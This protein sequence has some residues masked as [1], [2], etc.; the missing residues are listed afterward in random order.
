MNEFFRNKRVLVAGARGFVGTNL[1]DQLVQLGASVRGSVTRR[2]PPSKCGSVE[3]I[4]SDL[5][6]RDDCKRLVDEIDYVFMAAAC[7]SGAAVI[8]TNP[9]AHLTPNVVMNSYMLE[10]ARAAGVKKFCFVSSNV[11]YPVTDFP[12]AEDHTNFEFFEK[13]FIVGWMKQ[14]SELMCEMYSEHIDHPMSTIII[15][16]GNLYGPHDKF[17]WKESKVIPALIRR[18]IERHN[19]FVVWGN[20]QDIK[21]FLYI[22]DF[23]E[24]LLLAFMG[25]SQ[26]EIFNIA[27]GQPSTIN[28]V[29]REVLEAT[30]YV[31]AT[32]QYDLTQPQM[33][34]KRMINI[35]RIQ[36]R[37]GWSPRVSLS[38]G[39]ERTVE[40][41]RATYGSNAPEDFVA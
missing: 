40:W 10:A 36:K 3:Y 27:S 32:I 34:P 31:D 7:T 14:F 5:T 6:M 22:D 17:S 39:I 12:V 8:E 16:P 13:Y 4:E 18:A 11:V 38:E 23:I 21:D 20:G 29:L 1:V 35:E 26:Y 2:V 9:L 24:G 41:Y 33:I 28:Q 30:D 37:C 19:P 15:R 25:S